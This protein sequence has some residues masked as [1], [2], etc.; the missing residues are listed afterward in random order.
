MDARSNRGHVREVKKLKV[1]GWQGHRYECPPAAT[2][3]RQT[4]EICAAPSMAAVARAAGASYP[5]Q[6]FCLGQIEND[7]DVATAMAE[8]GVVFWH[9][10][11]Q[12]QRKRKWVRG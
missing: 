8:P 10:L 7:D 2:G 1:Y 4:W 3:G 9:P 11:D 5:R 6:L 12:L